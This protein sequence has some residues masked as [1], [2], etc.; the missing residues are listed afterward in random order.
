MKIAFNVALV[1]FVASPAIADDTSDRDE[2]LEGASCAS[3][4]ECGGFTCIE[5]RCQ[6]IEARLRG[7]TPW[8]GTL[9]HRAMFGNGKEYRAAIVATDI[10]AT[11]T[12]PLLMLATVSSNGSTASTLGVLCFVPVGFAGPIVHLANGRPLPAVISFFAWT[13]LAGSTF[14]VGGL[15]GLAFERDFELN[16]TAAWAA[17]LAFGATGAAALTFLDSWMARAVHRPEKTS[18]SSLRV[19]PGFVPTHGGAMASLGGSF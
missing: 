19:M 4:S 1:L 16:S 6:D 18:T 13:S 12:E 10:A 15:F 5:E 11:V 14:V 8:T 2:R 3:S 17:G 9:G 7:E